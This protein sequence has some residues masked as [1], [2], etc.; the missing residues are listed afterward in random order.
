M[1][2]VAGRLVITTAQ[3]PT[4]RVRCRA[5]HGERRRLVSMG[6]EKSLRDWAVLGFE[7]VSLEEQIKLQKRDAKLAPIGGYA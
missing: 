6:D 4:D 3:V 1:R 7:H 5:G 2:D